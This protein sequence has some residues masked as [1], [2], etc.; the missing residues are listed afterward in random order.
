MVLLVVGTES[1]M[2]DPRDVDSTRYV[3]PW[4]KRKRVF[5]P[6]AIILVI[7]GLIAWL[8]PGCLAAKGESEEVVRAFFEAGAAGDVDVAMMQW[9]SVNGDR[10][11][12]A[13]F[14]RTDP[15]GMFDGY[16]GINFSGFNIEMSSSGQSM[17][18]NG[19]AVYI[20]GSQRLFEV[21]L[22]KQS[23]VWRIQNIN[24]GSE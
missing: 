1:S 11:E 5:I 12:L 13:E 6:L 9:V 22:I 17:T 16:K 14:I 4:Y 7:A 24:I 2:Y 23:G 21:F 3:R 19:S 15:A 18:L 8:L 20:G 10:D